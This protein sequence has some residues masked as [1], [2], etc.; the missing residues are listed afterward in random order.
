[1]SREGTLLLTEVLD[2]SKNNGIDE[3]NKYSG[4]SSTRDNITIEEKTKRND[5]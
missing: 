3:T 4:K 5:L 1:V 2:K